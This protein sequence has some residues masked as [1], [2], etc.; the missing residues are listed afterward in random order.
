MLKT[1][2]RCLLACAASAVL[3]NAASTIYGSA[4]TNAGQGNAAGLSTLYTI[5]PGGTA[6]A[7]GPI[8]FAHVNAMDFAPNGTLYGVATAGPGQSSLITINRTTGAGTL[9]G[10]MNLAGQGVTCNVTDISF[11]PSDG[12]LFA[13]AC[14]AILTV[15]TST[16]AAT[17]VG[18]HPDAPIGDG[19]ALVFVGNTL[20]LGADTGLYTVDQA[21]GALTLAHTFTFPTQFGTN[22]PVRPKSMKVDLATGVLWAFVYSGKT[23]VPTPIT[24]ALGTIN[25]TTGAASFVGPM[26]SG[27]A[28][29]A[30]GTGAPTITSVVPPAANPAGGAT[31]VIN[32][33]NFTGATGVTFGGTA[34]T[35][36][37]VNSDTKITAV[38]PAHA[39]GT[40]S[41][42]VTTAAGSNA[43][44]T[45]FTYSVALAVPT[46]GEWG[47]IGL[48]GLL[49]IYACFKLRR[50]QSMVG[51]A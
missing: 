37:T 41:V 36:F 17:L 15:N 38:V 9:V 30:I 29:L 16:G 35:S 7:V 14:T 5:T 39:A 50:R 21:T 8:G 31:V 10:S 12:V 23:N 13:N 24:F 6:T 2:T 48:A 3:A 33:T 34:A 43:A 25:P 46:L 26:P 42:V 51:G 28:G 1:L 20:Y 18:T 19:Q 27:M 47:M 11:R 40:A 49:V 22:P 32:G 4:F 44:N 45:L